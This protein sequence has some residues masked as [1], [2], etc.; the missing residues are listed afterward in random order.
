M[1]STRQNFR[2][3]GLKEL[4]EALAEL[5]KATARNVLLRTLKKVA[6]PIADTAAHLAPDDPRTGGKDLHS[7]ILVQS[8]P[9]KKRENDVEVAVG[10]SQQTFYGMFQE[11]GTARHGPKPFLRPAWDGHV[12]E[13]LS[14][15]KNTLADEI[16][17][18]AK[19]L[20]RK[21]ARIA[22]SLK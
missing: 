17:K 14:G 5:P 6:Q 3:E 11:F 2:I 13:V 20:A 19:R 18:A 12:M 4:D 15:I 16:D 8:V 9:A 21:A 22:A 1:A 10:P 7:S